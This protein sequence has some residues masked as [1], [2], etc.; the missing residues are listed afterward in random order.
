MKPTQNPFL[1]VT[2]E[3]WLIKHLLQY[4]QTVWDID[5]DIRAGST[6]LLKQLH[7]SALTGCCRLEVLAWMYY[8]SEY[9]WLAFPNKHDSKSCEFGS[10]LAIITKKATAVML[11]C[12]WRQTGLLESWVLLS[13][14]WRTRSPSPSVRWLAR[15][16]RPHL[17][18]PPPLPPPRLCP[19]PPSRRPRRRSLAQTMWSCSPSSRSKTGQWSGCCSCCFLGR[20]SWRLQDAASIR[21]FFT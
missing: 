7:R 11:V 8:L 12:R 4:K 17:Y 1:V 2:I 9:K 5:W 20:L 16:P 18:R 13:H 19:R 15:W 3:S 6:H 21:N 10:E 14:G